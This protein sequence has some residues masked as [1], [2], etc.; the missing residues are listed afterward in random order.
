MDSSQHE[1]VTLTAFD[2]VTADAVVT[3]L[4]R[5]GIAVWQAAGRD[6][7]G[8]VQLEVRCALSREL[9]EQLRA[10]DL[11]AF[12]VLSAGDRYN[13]L[14][15]RLQRYRSD[16]FDDKYNRLR[17]DAPSR[18]I[19]DHIAKDG[20]WYIHPKQHRTLTVRES[21]RLQTFP[22]RF[23]FAGYRSNAYRQIGEAIPPILAL[24]VGASIR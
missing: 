17:W 11:D 23:R 3:V 7:H 20:Y 10:D 19:T 2:P 24:E 16:I 15:S 1:G 4:R 12:K 6:E 5:A 13:S 9:H 22:D 18:T 8:D 14:P 21:A